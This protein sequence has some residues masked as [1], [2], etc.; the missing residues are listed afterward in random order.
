MLPPSPSRAAAGPRPPR[1]TLALAAAA[2]F[3]VL[4]QFVLLMQDAAAGKFSF[5]HALL[6]YFG[7]FT[8]LTN[9]LA[10]L[11]LTL[12]WLAS[13]TRLGRFLGRPGVQTAVAAS[14]G[15]VGLVYH[16]VLRSLWHPQGW[17]L[18]ADVTMHYVVPIGFVLHWW[19]HVPTA[20]LH[21]RRIPAWSSYPLAYAA[22]ALVRGE[23]TGLW[24]Y[25]FIDAAALG[26]AAVARN[27]AVLLVLYA[28][29][30]VVL[31]AVGRRLGRH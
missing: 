8:I 1:T 17:V 10:A 31:V 28:T 29:L 9:L 22:Y 4:L 21:V 12:P 7:F 2:W 19:W 3:G 15:L 25:P 16:L 26:Y 30:C 13:A 18:V 23:L 14:L 11:A 5:G 6:L 20:S 27:T 24:P